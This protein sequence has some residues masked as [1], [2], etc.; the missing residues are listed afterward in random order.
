MSKI[1][2]IVPVYNVEC[3]LENMINSILAQTYTDFELLIIDDGS[4]DKSGEICDKFATK[5]SRIRV[6]HI[7]N[8]G[9]SNAR[10][11]G[12]LK[13]SGEYVHFADSD[14]YIEPNMYAEFSEIAKK[15][16]PDIIM[17]GSLQVNTKRNTSTVVAPKIET[18]LKD[19]EHIIDFLDGLLLNDTKCLIHYIW[20]KWY[21]K[22]FLMNRKL[23]FSSELN[24]GEDYVFNCYAIK[25][26]RTLY[27]IS[28]AYYHYFIRG[29]SLV[30]AFQSE[31]WK[32]REMLFNAHKSL[33]ES[34]GIWPENKNEIL[35]EEGKMCFAALRGVN[36]ERC[37]LS[38]KEKKLF[39]M[40]MYT[41]KQMVFIYFYL[42]H[43][44]KK[45]HKLWLFIIRTFGITGIRI[46]LVADYLN[47]KMG[48][49]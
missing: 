40:K 35:L 5:D 10:N 8:S 4:T 32:S 17:C 21:R 31:P 9:V 22:E 30:S 16:H 2:V 25:E 11:Y 33:Y 38:K 27:M 39:V 45:L 29:N 47:K 24:L 6:F 20:N 44:N 14:D 48:G 18:Y 23:T 19:R 42:K 49:N 34:Y 28:K 41:S 12:L 7:P 46:V 1:S 13:A 15:Y 3:Y 43:S 36:S 37:K 26:M